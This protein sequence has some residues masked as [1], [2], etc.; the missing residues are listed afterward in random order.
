MD[1]GRRYRAHLGRSVLPI[2]QTAVI[3]ALGIVYGPVVGGLLGSFALVSSGLIGYGLMR[4]SARRLLV[5][6]VA[7]ASLQ[8]VERWF[9]RSGAWAIVLSRSL[10]H[11][12]PEALVLV[13]GLARMPLGRFTTALVLG[14]VPI[15]FA[16]AAVGAGWAD[17]PI[18]ALAV[19]YVLP[20]ALLPVALHLMRGRE[21]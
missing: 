21:N 5:R 9:E 19:S 13:A 15:A 3:A 12:I 20:I 11:S 18:L 7:P 4:T 16:F 6:W 2:P 14:S 10:S 17:Q 8:K 1:L